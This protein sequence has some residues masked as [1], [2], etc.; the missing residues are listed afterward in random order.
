VLLARGELL[1]ALQLDVARPAETVP[2]RV[3]LAAS[4][5]W[6]LLLGHVRLL[7]FEALHR[8]LYQRGSKRA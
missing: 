7:L 2:R 4:R 6:N 1:A 3:L 5:A 8:S